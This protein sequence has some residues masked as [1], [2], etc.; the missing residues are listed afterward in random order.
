MDSIV[1]ISYRMAEASKQ[2]KALKQALEAQHIS[3]FLCDV[4]PGDDIARAI[5]GAL[6]KCHLAVIMGTSTYGTDTGFGCS[7]F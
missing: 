3:T 7:T 2:A 6:N 5:S 1:F 4:L